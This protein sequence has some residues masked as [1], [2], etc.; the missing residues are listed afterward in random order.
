MIRKEQE[1]QNVEVIKDVL[2][3]KCGNSCMKQEGTFK[4]PSFAELTAHWGYFSD[5]RD[6]EV[7]GAHLCQNCWQKFTQDFKYPDLVAEN[8]F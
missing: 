1:I 4:E 2:C 5:N 7:H 6:G 8:Q 3:N